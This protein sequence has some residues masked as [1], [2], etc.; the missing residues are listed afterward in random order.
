MTNLM[1][2]PKST[3]TPGKIQSEPKKETSNPSTPEEENDQRLPDDWASIIQCSQKVLR[4]FKMDLRD[5]QQEQEK[6]DATNQRPRKTLKDVYADAATALT[7]QPEDS[8]STPQSPP[9]ETTSSA[10]PTG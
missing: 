2:K 4:N 3:K 9:P 10:Q 6:P 7:L 8:P 1:K 5:P